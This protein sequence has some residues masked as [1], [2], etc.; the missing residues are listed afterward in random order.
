VRPVS[1]KKQGWC[2]RSEREVAAPPTVILKRNLF[3]SLRA[4]DVNTYT[5][6]RG[7]ADSETPPSNRKE[8]EPKGVGRPPPIILTTSVNLLTFKGEIRNLWSVHSNS[9]TPA[10]KLKW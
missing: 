1:A 2:M 6:G 10:T 3:A 7:G 9:E 5:T 8:T 4:V